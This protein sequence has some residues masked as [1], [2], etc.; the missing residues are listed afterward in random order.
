M[1]TEHRARAPDVTGA[2]GVFL[3]TGGGNSLVQTRRKDRPRQPA[4]LHRSDAYA[5]V[6]NFSEFTRSARRVMHAVR[7]LTR[8][9]P[10]HMSLPQ[11]CPLRAQ[12]LCAPWGAVHRGLHLDEVARHDQ[13]S[14]LTT[15]TSNGKHARLRR[16]RCL[17]IVHGHDGLQKGFVHAV[18]TLVELSNQT[19][20][21]VFQY[22]SSTHRTLVVVSGCRLRY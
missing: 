3:S 9:V 20:P 1:S 15:P 7:T 2:D 17:R 4:R 5:H 19:F 16:P 11:W 6:L 22:P 13:V 18:G 8:V 12:R 14:G 21:F 10:R